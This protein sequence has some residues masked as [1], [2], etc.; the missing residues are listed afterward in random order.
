[1]ETV[2]VGFSFKMR[3][4]SLCEGVLEGVKYGEYELKSPSSSN[5]FSHASSGERSGYV[6]W[7]LCNPSR[8]SIRIS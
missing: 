5:T 8:P 7:T 2:S 4:I 3:I 6:V 1:M